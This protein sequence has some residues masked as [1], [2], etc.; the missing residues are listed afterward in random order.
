METVATSLV[1]HFREWGIKHVFGV[2][3]KAIVPLILELGNQGV[4]Y[5]LSR[6]ECGAGYSA[7]G[8]A[9]MNKTLGVAIGTSGPGGTNM[10]TAAGQAKAY[11]QPVLFITGHASMK[12]N[13]RPIGQD[14]TFFSTDLVKMFEPV[15]LFSARV[16]RGEQFPIYFKHAIE[17]AM[18]GARGPVHLSLPQDILTELTSDFTMQ[19]PNTAPLTVS[20][21]L[22]EACDI[23]AS[24]EKPA[25][26]I[27]KG[28][29]ISESYEQVERFAELWNIPVI[30]TP[31]GKGA[32]RSNHPLHIGPFG[33][34]G[35][36]EAQDYLESGVDILVVIGTKLSDMSVPVSTEKMTPKQI[37]HFDVDGTFI[38]K[39]F[40]SP[41]LFIQ[42]DARQNL[43]ELLRIAQSRVSTLESPLQLTAVALEHLEA[44]TAA[45]DTFSQLTA[46]EVME[47]LGRILPPDAIVFGDDGSHS[48]HAIRHLDIKKAGFFR[49]DDVF[50]AMGHAIG[51]SVGAQMAAPERK[52]VC[53]TG[54]GCIF[55]QGSE[56]STAVNQ[57]A[58]VLFVVLNNG[59]LDMVNK[60]MRNSV[61]RSD[62]TVY[63]VPL[64][65]SNYA[66]AMGALTFVARDKA[67]FDFALEQSLQLEATIVI[68][69]LVDPEEI[70]PTLARG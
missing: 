5:V 66:G 36:P 22:F 19:L 21:K 42:G 63:E 46:Q 23:L 35:I 16:E 44:S 61:G 32:F 11:H 4:Q 53:L 20:S 57:N 2:P 70:P 60:G 68:E 50:A 6:H 49:F 65:V 8:Y 39:T 67:E 31:G 48:Y 30:T 28:V 55:M 29:H 24:A 59:R 64:E 62:G 69:A 14:S 33:L 1:R 54:D 45:T 15:T 43:N 37:L 56:I 12:G 26:I 34:G 47:S 41:V 51:F 18:L 9:M 13:G 38:G 7:A 3:G 27:G 17:H 58:H 10:L 25:L 40:P 52:I